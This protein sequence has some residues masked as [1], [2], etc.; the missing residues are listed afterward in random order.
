[1]IQRQITQ[2]RYQIKSYIYNGGP[3]EIENRIWFIELH[4]FQW[5]WTASNPL[6]KVTL[7]FD[8]EYL[9]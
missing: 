1:M 5:P 4:H 2:K 7:Y 6:F 8:A 9:I 3:I